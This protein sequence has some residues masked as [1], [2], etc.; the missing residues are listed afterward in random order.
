MQRKGEMYMQLN[1]KEIWE[2]AEKTLKRTKQYKEYSD[3]KLDNY[4]VLYVI[5]KDKRP[6]SDEIYVYA[7]ASTSNQEVIEFNVFGT[8][9]AIDFDFMG[10]DKELLADLQL[11]YEIVDMTMDCH[12]SVWASIEE[13][14]KENI[15]YTNGLQKYLEYC[16]QN[17]ITKERLHKEVNYK[18][19]DVMT[20]YEKKREHSKAT[21]EHER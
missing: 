12:Y 6:T 17:N 4:K 13:V 21:V 7:L 18:G 16:K 14:G 5:A 20:L 1:K 15:R 8:G 9:S 2:T 3:D 19:M 11:G 10:H